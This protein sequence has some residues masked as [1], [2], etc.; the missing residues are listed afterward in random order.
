LTAERCGEILINRFC[1][2][3]RTFSVCLVLK[4]ALYKC[5]IDQE[6]VDASA[7]MPGKRCMC[8]LQIATLSCMK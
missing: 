2:C 5:I 3:H 4:Q 1:T 7:Y 8:T 6:L